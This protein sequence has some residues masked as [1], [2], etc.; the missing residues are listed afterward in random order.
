MNSA[1]PAT[2]PA[3]P[4]ASPPVG[5]RWAPFWVLTYVTLWPVSRV[6]EAVLSLGAITALVLLLKARFR[7]G[8]H[9][10]APAAWA[11]TTALFFCYWLPQL[12]SSPDALDMGDALKKTLGN[13]RYLPF[14]WLIAIAVATDNGRRTVFAGL[15][16]IAVIWSIDLLLQA[17]GGNSTSLLN[18]LLDGGY[19]WVRDKAMCE[20]QL[21]RGNGRINGIFGTCNPVLGIVLAS[22]SPFVLEAAHRRM[23][24]RGW[25]LAAAVLGF[26]ILMA[27][28]R[29]AW[30]TYA[31]VLAISGWRALGPKVLIGLGLCAALGLAGI[32]SVYPPLAERIQRTAAVFDTQAQ[33]LDTALSGRARIWAGASCMIETHPINGVGVRNFR[34]AWPE[35]DPAQTIA[36]APNTECPATTAAW[37]KGP[38]LH[39]HQWVL[40][41][42]SETGALGMILWLAGI[43]LAWRAWRWASPQARARARPAAQALAVTLFPLNTHLAFYSAFWGGVFLLLVALYAGSLLAWEANTDTADDDVHNTP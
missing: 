14:L 7:D 12:F 8:K 3:L 36:C 24:G 16:T 4:P 28:A 39:A 21:A 13:L 20:G 22:L 38:A 25:F 27:G 40:E 30:L 42:L 32:A 26:A 41:V 43:A 37:G 33:G 18:N 10:L 23:G 29:A 1:S 6:S 2:A 34:H 31:L 11:L 9:L 17:I 5:W 35:C 19:Q 15:S